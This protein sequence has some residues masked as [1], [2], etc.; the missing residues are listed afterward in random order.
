MNTRQIPDS[1]RDSIALVTG[2]NNGIG[3]E[4]TRRLLGEGWQVAV[5]IR[6]NFADGDE[7]VQSALREGRLRIYRAELTDFAQLRAALERIKQEEPKLDVVF[8]NAGGSLAEL[9]FSPQG[10]EMHYELQ[11]VVPYIVYREL[12][13]LLLRGSLRTVIGT[14]SN[15]FNFVKTFDPDKLPHPSTFKQL[16]GAYAE[17]KLALSL[18][19]RALASREASDGIKLRSAD[20]G[21]NNTVRKG[22]KS[23]L[24][25]PVNYLMR[26]FPGPA[27]GASRLYEAAFGPYRDKA[28]VLI[29]KKGIVDLRFAEHAQRVLDNVDR[30]YREEFAAPKKTSNKG[31]LV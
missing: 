23:G 1:N 6:S 31:S 19:T 13:D 2:A 25:F 10:R 11:T 20:P 8:N 5:L 28:G 15:A 4:L 27:Q 22:K 24:P 16:T 9:S 26:F 18:W 3:L 29:D 30:V 14:S 17:S 12:K 7:I 21:P